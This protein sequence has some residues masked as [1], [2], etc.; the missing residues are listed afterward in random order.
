VPTQIPSVA[1]ERDYETLLA[2][3]AVTYPFVDIDERALATTFHTTG[4]SGR[5][6]G[7]SFTHRQLVLH[8][9]AVTATL[10]NQPTGQGLRRGDV[11]MPITPMFHVHAWGLPY[12]ATTLGLKQ[13]YPGRYVAA[14]LV[15]LK[16]AE[17]VTFSHGVPTIL[18]MIIDALGARQTDAWTMIVGGSALPS[19]LVEAAAERGITAVAGYGMSETAPVVSIARHEPG[20]PRSST[21]T[22][23]LAGRPLPLVQRRVVDD[24]FRDVP[25][26]EPGELVLRAPWLTPAY[27]DDPQASET[28]WHGGWLHTQDVVRVTPEGELAICDRIKDV[29]K[30]GGEWV[31]SA[32]MENLIL[33]HKAISAAAFIGIPDPHWGERPIAFLRHQAGGNGVA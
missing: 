29:I 2:T 18:Q 26:G 8:T 31:S 4:T 33:G 25:E 12:V 19:S 30:T 24:G 20:D 22:L 9:L 15:K 14:N 23:R 17:G 11:Y 27:T 13:V 3:Y 28:L 6:K 7:V 32:D 10:A 1:T 16:E 21:E 5:P